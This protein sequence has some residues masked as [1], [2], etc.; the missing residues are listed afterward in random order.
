MHDYVQTAI[1][2]STYETNTPSNLNLDRAFEWIP[3]KLV[4]GF[5]CIYINVKDNDDLWETRDIQIEAKMVKMA[6]I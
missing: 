4:Y 2:G 3:G 5:T 1:R 6:S